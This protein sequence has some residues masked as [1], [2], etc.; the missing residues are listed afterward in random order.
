MSVALWT[1]SLLAWK[2]DLSALKAR[3]GPVFTRREL[4]ETGGAFL[5]ELLS[6]I[7]HKT[8]WLMAEQA[9]AAQP[10]RMQSLLGGSR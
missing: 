8:G 9:G 3:L 2:R 4:R 6:G 5:D 10:Y 1:G 7:E